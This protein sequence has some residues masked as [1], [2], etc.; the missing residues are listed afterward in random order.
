ME[1]IGV[2]RSV[3]SQNHFAHSAFDHEY[4]NGLFDPGMI[5]PDRINTAPKLGGK[6]FDQP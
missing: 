5:Y 4:K 1:S 2:Q 3:S 6:Q